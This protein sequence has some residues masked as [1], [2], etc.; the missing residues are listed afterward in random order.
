MFFCRFPGSVHV[1]TVFQNSPLFRKLESEP[2]QIFNS[3]A[4]HVNADSSF[5]LQEWLIALYKK[6]NGISLKSLNKRLPQEWS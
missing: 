6:V 2:I 1:S 5:P 4:Y 3:R